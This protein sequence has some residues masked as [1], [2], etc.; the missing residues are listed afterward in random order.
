LAPGFQTSVVALAI[1]RAP[2]VQNEVS[3][4]TKKKFENQ[5]RRWEKWRPSENIG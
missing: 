3:T 2:S 1:I 4:K 5:E